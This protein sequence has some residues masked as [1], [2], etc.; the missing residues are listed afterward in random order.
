MFS[1]YNVLETI[2]R[3]FISKTDSVCK[4]SLIWRRVSTVV[5]PQQL[6][7]V[8]LPACSAAAGK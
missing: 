1:L 6:V 4:Y 2:S 3:N 5:K 7:F 8:P